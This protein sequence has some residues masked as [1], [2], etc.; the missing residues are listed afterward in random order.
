MSSGRVFD[1][2]PEPSPDETPD[3]RAVDAA[4]AA[5]VAAAPLAGVVTGWALGV[6]RPLLAAVGALATLAIYAMVVVG[7][8]AERGI[9]EMA[10]RAS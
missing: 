5:S 6:G 8:L 7:R 1:P 10:D 3:L 9:I 4:F 2:E